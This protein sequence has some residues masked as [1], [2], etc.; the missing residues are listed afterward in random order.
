MDEG[1]KE[2]KGW[3]VFM[4]VLG[5][6]FAKAAG[7]GGEI[8]ALLLWSLDNLLA[9]AA[10]Q[11]PRPKTKKAMKLLFIRLVLVF[12]VCVCVFVRE[13]SLGCALTYP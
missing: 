12:G 5:C 13:R 11:T 8:G 7:G 6:V 9:F 4:H 2:K 1:E 3:A 10:T